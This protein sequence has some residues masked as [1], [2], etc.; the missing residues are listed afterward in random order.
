MKAIGGPRSVL[1]DWVLFSKHSG[2]KT[3]YQLLA[4]TIDESESGP[5]VWSALPGQPTGENIGK[6]HQL[7]WVTFTGGDPHSPLFSVHELGWSD[8]RDGTRKVIA[9]TRVIIFDWRDATEAQLSYGN[10]WHMFTGVAWPALDAGPVEAEGNRP[11]TLPPL[12][13]LD[14]DSVVAEIEELGF[15][16]TAAAAA[17]LVEGSHVVLVCPRGYP[18]LEQRLSILDAIVGLLPYA[19]RAQ[20]RVGTWASH[21]AHHG[22]DLSFAQQARE[23]QIEAVV[24]GSPPQ[25]RSKAGQNYLDSML[26]L[27]QRR[28]IST[29]AFVTHLAN[30]GRPDI[31]S[32]AQQALDLMAGID[33][34]SAVAKEIRQNRGQLDR[35]LYVLRVLSWDSLSP[36]DRS[37]TVIPWLCD[38]AARREPGAQ[39]ALGQY[40]TD[41]IARQLGATVADRL[42]ETVDSAVNWIE[43]LGEHPEAAQ[44]LL[45][46]T[47]RSALKTGSGPTVARLAELLTVLPA[48]P[49]V[50]SR[51]VHQLL[52]ADQQAL[53]V[54]IA[55]VDDWP[56]GAHLAALL[57]LWYAYGLL[58]DWCRPFWT[59][60][61][62]GEGAEAAS[63]IHELDRRVTYG[64]TM[65]VQMAFMRGHAGA[66][67]PEVWRGVSA[68]ASR[69]HSG[70]E[71]DGQARIVRL[72]D[73]A[74]RSSVPSAQVAARIDL[75][76]LAL[77]G[78]MPMLTRNRHT[79]SAE[80]ETALR[81]GWNDDVRLGLREPRLTRLIPAV[82]GKVPSDPAL[83]CLMRLTTIDP[84]IQPLAVE[85]IR[86]YV[87]RDVPRLDRLDPP[88][89]VLE[90]LGPWLTAM[91]TLRQLCH[92]NT[93]AE[94]IST[95]CVDLVRHG[96]DARDAVE[97]LGPWLKRQGRAGQIVV[98]IHTLYPYAR[99]GNNAVANFLDVL[100]H[101]LMTAEFQELRITGLLKSYAD[102][103]TWTRGRAEN[104]VR[105][106]N[107]L[108]RFLGRV[109]PQGR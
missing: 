93:P 82:V 28:H 60:I 36:S 102:V 99:S 89:A 100:L 7:P 80:Y 47:V 34:A 16:W 90:A 48:D 8:K 94:D 79:M 78:W 75:L 73:T 12:P 63:G 15:G 77:L 62:G 70:L 92:Q 3:D 13:R 38:M 85:A 51:A 40:W 11:I 22:L 53:D 91:R 109:S 21:L 33:L 88:P 106:P 18:Q 5:L 32:T 69:T 61:Q 24:G 57:T 56:D 31:C 98:L 64:S 10:A 43:I 96:G 83:R 103:M 52:V 54:V 104:L 19:W 2:H 50:N 27:A 55:A 71:P 46:A 44:S 86:T 65:V 23:Q 42:A 68:F 6:A 84:G 76:A 66:L 1:V 81:S 25:P 9:P 97:L 108:S 14:P 17:C 105:P 107:R 20:L 30:L 41:E 37:G 35:V 49:A 72:I 45:V 58:P 101:R 4:S 29:A 95:A 67:G 59:A 26:D 87:G 39:E 74:M